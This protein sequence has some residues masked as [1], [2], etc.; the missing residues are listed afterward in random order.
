MAEIKPVHIIV[1]TR[2]ER[3]GI[4]AKLERLPGVTIERQ[5]LSSGDYILAEGC[6]V[7]R[8]SADDLII[9]VIDG[10]IFEQIARMQLEYQEVIVLIEG[11]PYQTRSAIAPE[12]IDGA[13]SWL[14]LLA[15]VSVIQSPNVNVTPRIL[16][17]MAI[18]KTHGLGYEVSLRAAKPKEKATL[19]RYM[20]ESLPSVGPSTAKTLLAH[21]NTPHAIFTASVEDLVQVKGIGKKTAETIFNSVRESAHVAK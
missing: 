21:F 19:A 3:S 11:D 8:K 18:H 17:R 16:A 5:E 7:E 14:S 10:R 6:A 1:D 12:A 4:A 15:G 13:L 20:V 9:S 2:E